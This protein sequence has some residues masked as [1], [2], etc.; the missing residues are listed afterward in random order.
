M[1]ILCIGYIA[2]IGY[3]K[4]GTSIDR[5][6]GKMPLDKYSSYLFEGLVNFKRFCEI[7]YYR[8]LEIRS[9]KR[10]FKQVVQGHA[11]A[12]EN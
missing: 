4:S 8:T 10:I 12:V 1:S 9:D 7:R 3:D 6:M 11:C 5:D 2:D